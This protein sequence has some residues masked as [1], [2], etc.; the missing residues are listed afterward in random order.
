MKNN[1]TNASSFSA[2]VEMPNGKDVTF[3]VDIPKN[4]LDLT[5]DEVEDAI[6]KELYAY[7]GINKDEACDEK[8]DGY[9]I[10][11]IV[12]NCDDESYPVIPEDVDDSELKK[13]QEFTKYLVLPWAT[14]SLTPEAKLWLSLKDNGIIDEDA[15]FDFENYHKLVGK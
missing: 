4:E 11:G 9:K 14:Y 6:Y 1:K 5:Y 13:S 7:L 10:A 2:V 8:Y 3:D 12:I 15:P